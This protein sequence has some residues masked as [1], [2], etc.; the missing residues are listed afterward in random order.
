M[1]EEQDDQLPYYAPEYDDPEDN[2][3]NN[4]PEPAPDQEVQV[5]PEAERWAPQMPNPQ[6][7]DLEA[8]TLTQTVATTI[9]MDPATPGVEA[10]VTE[11]VTPSGTLTALEYMTRYRTLAAK[12]SYASLK[13][14]LDHPRNTTLRTAVE[15]V[16]NLVIPP[17]VLTKSPTEVLDWL[18]QEAAKQL[19]IGLDLGIAP[20]VNRDVIFPV[21]ATR[22]EFGRATYRVSQRA[23]TTCSI[24]EA[25][26]RSLLD[27]CESGDE[28]VD[29]LDELINEA[30]NDA[31]F[32]F[33]NT[34]DLEYDNHEM[35]DSDDHEEY[36]ADRHA[37][38]TSVFNV[39][40][41]LDPERASELNL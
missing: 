16:I 9:T 10:T 34:D 20:P 7:R 4:G 2:P 27:D 37:V 30:L 17:E 41:M 40:R 29:R 24:T 33:E 18:N 1:P 25:E 13:L 26:I 21:E 19:A 15:T 32:T 5:Q 31:D 12:I 23:R 22:T 6:Y 35:Q 8:E 36:P 28:F 14:W 39:V 38:H 3:D 11:V